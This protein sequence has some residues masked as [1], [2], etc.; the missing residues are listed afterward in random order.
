MEAVLDLYAEAADP[1][2]PRVGFDETTKQLVAEVRDPL[3]M[4]PGQ[5]ERYD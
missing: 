2:R 3:P 5:V 1:Q 4:T